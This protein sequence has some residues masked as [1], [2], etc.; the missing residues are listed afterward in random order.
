LQRKYFFD[1][2]FGEE[3]KIEAKSTTRQL[4]GR[5]ASWRGTPKFLVIVVEWGLKN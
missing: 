5:P 4:A 1:S 2:P 3:K